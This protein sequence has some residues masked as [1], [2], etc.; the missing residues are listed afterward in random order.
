MLV[1]GGGEP[2]QGPL[3]TPP[4]LQSLL[5]PWPSRS[6]P[7][8]R[9]SPHASIAPTPYFEPVACHGRRQRHGARQHRDL[10]PHGMRQPQGARIQQLAQAN[11][12]GPIGLLARLWRPPSSSHAPPPTRMA[13]SDRAGVAAYADRTACPLP[14]AG[15]RRPRHGLRRLAPAR[16]GRIASAKPMIFGRPPASALASEDAMAT[17][18][19]VGCARPMACAGRI[20]CFDPR[21]SD[22][23]TSRT[24]CAAPMAYANRMA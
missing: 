9:R 13:C 22:D 17:A 5:A 8:A 16:A 15:L 3:W 4:L 12:A 7:T 14:M 21:A 11:C 10:H 19:P 1:V 2:H 20:A 18:G 24:A 23:L 6:S